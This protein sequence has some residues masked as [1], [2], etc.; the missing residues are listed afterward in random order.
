ML[1]NLT[2]IAPYMTIQKRKTIMKSFV[3]S[4]FSYCPLIWML[5]SRRLINKINSIHERALRITYPDN[6]SAFKELVNKNNSV[7][8]HHEYL[9][10]LAT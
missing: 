2:R 9:Q 7:S 8:I 6:R 3:A 10:V 5:H 1:N 4:Q